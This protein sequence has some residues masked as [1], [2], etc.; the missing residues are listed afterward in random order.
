MRNAK[1]LSLDETAGSPYPLDHDE[2]QKYYIDIKTG[3]RNVVRVGDRWIK[4]SDKFYDCAPKIKAKYNTAPEPKTS[5]HYKG[6]E[7]EDKY[8]YQ[9]FF[10]LS[11]KR[12]HYFIELGALDGVEFS[13]SY[14]FDMELGWGGVLIEG[15]TSNYLKLEQNRGKDPQKSV[16]TVHLAICIESQF[17]K[18]SGT[19]PMAAAGSQRSPGGTRITTVPCVPMQDVLTMA[20]LP[21][22]DFYSIDVEGAEL[23]VIHS[24]DFN[25]V[26]AHTLL[27]EMRPADEDVNF[28]N[29]KIRRALY[30]R[31][32]CR[33]DNSVGHNNEAW[34]NATWVEPK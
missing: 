28:A 17:I 21:Y 7:G 8:M 31:G 19:G 18:M 1:Q 22:V 27:I 30:A 2:L 13:N 5:V 29:A 6:Q 15:E 20:K 33:Y 25:S 12:P 24:H 4:A 32:F 26:P 16:T 34:I 9:H 11:K 3:V 23:A 14:F 10:H